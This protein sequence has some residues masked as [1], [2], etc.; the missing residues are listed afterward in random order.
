MRA[1][2]RT[3]RFRSNDRRIRFRRLD[4][5]ESTTSPGR[6]HQSLTAVASNCWSREGFAVSPLAPD[7][8]G[9]PPLVQQITTALCL[10][11][12]T[13]CC[14]HFLVLGACV[15]LS[16]HGACPDA[17]PS[18]LPPDTTTFVRY[19][20]PGCG[21]TMI[22]RAV[23]SETGAYCFTINGPEIMSK[24]SGESETNLRK[25]FED[26]E[27]NSP[28][29]IFI[30][31]IGE[32]FTSLFVICCSRCSSVAAGADVD[33]AL[34]RGASFPPAVEVKDVI[35]GCLSFCLHVQRNLRVGVLNGGRKTHRPRPLVENAAVCTRIF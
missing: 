5:K 14:N 19:G 3:F 25:A 21:K 6:P 7:V 20:P 33:F 1:A 34:D 29:I 27:A 31:E 35:G 13:A 17:S 2:L 26:A 8:F 23:A 30:D 11:F 32:T 15:H 18:A 24:L 9:D 12:G 28:A 22:A 4:L 10:V 16:H